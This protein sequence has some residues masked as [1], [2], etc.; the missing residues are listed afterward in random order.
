[1]PN[2]LKIFIG[3]GCIVVILAFFGGRYK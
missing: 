2:D 1:M 3:C